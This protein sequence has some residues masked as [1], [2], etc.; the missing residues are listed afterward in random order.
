MRNCL[1]QKASS[2]IVHKCERYGCMYISSGCGLCCTCLGKV[3]D[4]TI[5]DWLIRKGSRALG[6]IEDEAAAFVRW[7]F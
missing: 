3:L 6:K 1:N 7:I 2:W 4:K 5:N